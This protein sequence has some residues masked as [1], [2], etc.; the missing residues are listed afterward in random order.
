M[1]P[2]RFV[3]DGAQW[4]LE[5]GQ[6]PSQLTV[7]RDGEEL[8]VMR[9]DPDHGFGRVPPV[10]QPLLG[11]LGEALQPYHERLRFLQRAR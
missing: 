8:G 7:F 2:I 1:D 4:S 9:Y 3:W 11:P 5:L 10:L 6:D